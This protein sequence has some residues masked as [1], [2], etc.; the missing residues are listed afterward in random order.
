MRIWRVYL[1]GFPPLCL[2]RKSEIFGVGIKV[3]VEAFDPE[4]DCDSDYFI[5]WHN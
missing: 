2:L 1:F 4:L 5:K 3:A